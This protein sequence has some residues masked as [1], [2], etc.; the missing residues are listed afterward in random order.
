MKKFNILAL[1]IFATTT[2]SYAQ[3]SKKPNKEYMLNLVKEV[4]ENF[5]KF[6]LKFNNIYQD[7]QEIYKAMSNV[8]NVKPEEINELEVYRKNVKSFVKI[9]N[10]FPKAKDGLYFVMSDVYNGFNFADK[11]SKYTK[12]F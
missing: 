9:L 8:I 2:S 1:L 3:D 5:K 6:G 4:D 12:K 11:G 10:E 7:Y